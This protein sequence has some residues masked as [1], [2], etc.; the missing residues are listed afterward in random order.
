MNRTTRGAFKNPAK[1]GDLDA[2]ALPYTHDRLINPVHLADE[3]V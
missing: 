2:I 1:E 3:F